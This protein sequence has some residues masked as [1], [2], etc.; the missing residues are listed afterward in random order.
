MPPNFRNE[1]ENKIKLLINNEKNKKSL[2]KFDFGN[3]KICFDKATGIHYG[4]PSCEGCKV[5]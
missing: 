1:S 2:V 3:C 5:N 4:I